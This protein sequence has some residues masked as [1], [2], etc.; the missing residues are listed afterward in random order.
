MK[1]MTT[2][3]RTDY[4]AI[5]AGARCAGAAT[6]MLLARRGLRV[7]VVD[8][9]D[10]GSDTIST[11]ALMRG[12]VMQLARWGLLDAVRAAGA[13]PIRSATFHYGAEAV[14]VPIRPDG[15]VDALYAPRRA[16]LDRILV[17]AAA[18][19][20]AEFRFGVTLSDLLRD[21]DGRVTG[22]RLADRGGALHEVSAR[23]VIGADGVRSTVAEKAGAGGNALG[24]AATAV[25][26]GY[27]PGLPNAGYNWHYMPGMTAGA[28]PTTGGE[29]CVFVSLPAAGFRREDGVDALFRAGLACAAP[30]LSAQLAGREPNG[31][32]RLFGGVRGHMRDCAGAGWALVGDAGY[33]KDPV[34]AH[35]ITDAFRDAELLA[36][37]VIAGSDQALADYQHLRDALSLPLF[38]VTDAIAAFDWTLETLKPRL[39]TLNEAMKTEVAVLSMITARAPLPPLPQTGLARA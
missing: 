22:A 33:F 24:R 20:G 2:R 37:A 19:A 3:P 18:A 38:G 1:R 16:V 28:I 15:D 26:F 21:R 29:T 8:R 11:H 31:R 14:T 5:I 35:G 23:I 27:F 9:G 39:A 7:L 4:D 17:D 12:A 10:Y 34:T 6:A 36:R 32:L 25:I 30:A 13:A